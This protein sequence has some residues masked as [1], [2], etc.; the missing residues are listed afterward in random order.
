MR[1]LVFQHLAVEHP[2]VFLD[3]WRD[4][5]HS[6]DVVA[7]DEDAPIPPLDGYD[8]LAVMGGPMDVWQEAEFPWLR[9]EMDAIA[10]WV[11]DL[12]RPYLGICLG[13][14]LLG[15]ALGGAVR[16][17]SRPEVG[18]LTVDLTPAGASDPLFAGLPR[19]LETLQWHGA[20]VADLPEGAVSLAQSPLCPVQAM[21]WGDRAYGLQFHVETTEATVG[22]WAAIPEYS[23]SLEA[24][25]GADGAAALG[26]KMRAN[27]AAS[28]EV[29][30]RLHRN[31][32]AL[33]ASV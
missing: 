17:M 22:D 9:R 20:E 1:I 26:R 6:W 18:Y 11:R 25:L 7:F 3:F 32:S 31:F 16:P 33:L 5:G 15:A 14:Q 4:D 13:H 30:L 2:G 29:A 8:L 23:A 10:T 21:R 27:H 19:P 24:A 12:R 28:R